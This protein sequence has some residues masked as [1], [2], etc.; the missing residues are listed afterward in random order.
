ANGDIPVEQSDCLLAFGSWLEKNG[1]AIFDTRPW[2]V[3][4]DGDVRFTSTDD[5]LYT[6]VRGSGPRLDDLPL[7]LTPA[8]QTRVLSADGPASV[9]ALTPKDGVSVRGR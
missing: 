5:T 2:V 8:V 7:E 3:P 4:G 9:V 6:I 1:E